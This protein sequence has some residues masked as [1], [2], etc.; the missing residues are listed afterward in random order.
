M[1]ACMDVWMY[2]CMDVWMYGCMDVCMYVCL[3][4]SGESGCQSADTGLVKTEMFC[5]RMCVCVCVLVLCY[6]M[7]VCWYVGMLACGYVQY[8]YE[9]VWCGMAWHIR[10]NV[11]ERASS[12]V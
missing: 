9:L 5:T 10:T 11:C 12:I 7:Y 8:I 6:V 2:G 1:Y 4:L 3:S